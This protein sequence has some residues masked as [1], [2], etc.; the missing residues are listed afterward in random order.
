MML[1]A[2]KQQN[3][4]SAL[5]GGSGKNNNLTIPARE[6]SCEAVITVYLALVLLIVTGLI[7]TI[8]ESA[9]V[10]A[11]KS[12]LY[13][14][15]YMAAD[16][17]FSSFAEPVFE[18]YG[19]MFLWLT[20][21]GFEN[22][23]TD[24]VQENLD[25][26]A[27][28]S[29]VF[30]DLY[31]LSLS[32]VTLT[33]TTSPVDNNGEVFAE[34]VFEYMQYFLAES[35]LETVLDNLSVFEQTDAVSGFME[36]ISDKQEIFTRV[37]DTVSDIS[38][39][40][41]TAQNAD[42]PSNYLN[43]LSS[44]VE[45]YL[46]TEDAS[47]VSDFNS[48]LS[49][50]KIS[51]EALNS[52]LEE[53]AEDSDAYYAAAADAADAAD[54]LEEELKEETGSLSGE[55]YETLLSQ[56]EE[57][58]QKSADTDYDY[59]GVAAN[60]TIVSEYSALLSSL[61]ALYE[62]TDGGLNSENAE[63][64]LSIVSEYADSFAE[65]DLSALSVN[66]EASTVQEEDDSFLNTVS[67]LFSSGFL[68]LV[69]ENVSENEVETE[70]FPSITAEDETSSDDDESLLEAGYDK[71]VF[72]EYVLQHFGCYTQTSSSAALA[73]ETEYIIA[74]NSSD[75][76]NLSSVAM[77][78]ALIRGSLNFIS[79]LNDSEKTAEAY[80]LA[81]ALVG[82]TGL[83][84]LIKISQ[85]LIL[86]AWA[87]AEAVA[88]VKTLLSGGKVDTIKSADDWSISISALKNLSG[89][90]ISSS[91]SSD[92]GLGYEAYLRILLLMKNENALYLRTLDMIQA[93]MCANENENFLISDC[94]TSAELEAGYE[95]PYL[96]LSFS[97]V[98]SLAGATGSS[99]EISI[100]LSCGY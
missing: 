50:L 39:S 22:S 21:S 96:F 85:L 66:I 31:G 90:E 34:Q 89:S 9:R 41:K 84:I 56:I 46:E 68:G 32:D 3:F 48:A 15:T 83:P 6:K 38:E 44:A 30:T 33:S 4:G 12:R 5:K 73:Y 8:T 59:F 86:S 24:Y 58:R 1:P 47:A 57:L 16:S 75:E 87:M 54:A 88:D 70:A 100:P 20:E 80:T 74:G 7:F 19:V 29:L 10:S 14:I 93:N 60:S 51:A 92:S 99:F 27:L 61:D 81:T 82:F 62:R 28:S 95:I 79:I 65:L 91:P 63:E 45:E 2:R 71:A 13:S 69:A 52:S 97:F 76:E 67:A 77:Q 37:E 55:I 18:D 17:V 35:A 26:S 25:I 78:I 36:K 43:A 72:C 23:F 11:A 42:N 40:I 98:R 94:I 49:S 53:I 64:L